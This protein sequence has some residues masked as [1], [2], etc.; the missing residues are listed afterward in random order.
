MKTS[1]IIP[2]LDERDSIEALMQ[3]LLAQTQRPDEIVVADGG[4]TDGTRELLSQLQAV[5]DILRVVPGP[6]PIAE[7]RNAAISATDSAVIACTDAG[8]LPEPQWLEYLTAP[9]ASGAEWVAG[10][11]RPQG[12]SVASTA[13]GAVMMTT[14][15]EVDLDNFLPGGSSQAF[16][17]TAWTRA[18][19]FPEGHTVGEDTLFGERMRALG[20]SPVFVPEAVVAWQPPISV[21]SMADKAWQWGRADGVNQVRTGAYAK[22]LL[23]YWFFPA[24]IVIAAL[25]NGWLGL[26]GL[27]VYLVLVAYRTRHKYEVVP[28]W[29]KFFWVPWAHI[30]QQMFQSWGWV[31]G[32][33]WRRLGRK[34]ASRLG[35]RKLGLAAGT[36]APLRHNVDLLVRSESEARH[37]LPDLPTT[38]RV[39]AI[40]RDPA[41]PFVT[42]S[43]SPTT[44]EPA[45]APVTV[46]YGATVVHSSM[47]RW[48]AMSTCGRRVSL[49]S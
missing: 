27:L 13:A 26:T 45:V 10:F 16:L 12:L 35:L 18:G 34:I 19:G 30:R 38:Y 42:A 36:D 1:V 5:I 46:E 23:A 25:L 37:W 31:E 33:G 49:I 6:G 47:T 40:V 24:L 11:Y 43:L 48:H 22:V 20:Y 14:R 7:N 4:S 29:T 44:S 9:F 21:Q 39:G 28:G 15:G 32:Y 8:C 17:R 3:A 2:V 41:I